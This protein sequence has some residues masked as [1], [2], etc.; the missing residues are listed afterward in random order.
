MSQNEMIEVLKQ[1][2]AKN[3][4]FK[5]V[6]LMWA[7]RERARSQVTVTALSARMKKE[8]F[9]FPKSRYRDILKFLAGAGL[10]KLDTAPN[11]DIRALKEIKVSLQSLGKSVCSG[12]KDLKNI[13][14][15]NKYQKVAVPRQPSGAAVVARPQSTSVVL[16]FVINGKAINV[17]VPQGLTPIEIGTLVSKFHDGVSK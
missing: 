17:S 7:F 11:G 4:T 8:G 14:K 1:E 3:E 15:R 10:G 16:T 6:C 9:D 13:Q 2:A 12:S 5:T